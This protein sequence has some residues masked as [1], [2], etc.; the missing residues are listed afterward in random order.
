MTPT[1]LTPKT[2]TLALLLLAA[3]SSIPTAQACVRSTGSI[4]RDPYVGCH[5]PNAG[6][7]AELWDNGSRICTGPWRRDQDD[8]F[9]ATCVA[10]AVFAVS[11]N[12]RHAWYRH[13]T[14][15]F[16]WNQPVTENRYDCGWGACDDRGCLCAQCVNYN[17][18]VSN[19]C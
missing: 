14:A 9:S 19:Y 12:G 11:K 4:T 17:W 7:E 16:D 15:T 18:D 5:G 6:I 1:T 2:T 13:D 3:A 8:N 10:G